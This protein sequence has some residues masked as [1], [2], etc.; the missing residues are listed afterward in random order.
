MDLKPF[1][2]DIDE[3]IGE[4]AEGGSTSLAEMKSVWLSKKFTYIFEASPSTNQACFMQSLFAYCIGYVVSTRSLSHRLGGLYCLYCLFE[5]QPFRPPFKIYLSLGELKKL[6]TLVADAKAKSI[7]VVCALVKSM[8]DR[9]MFLIGVVDINECSATERINEVTEIQNARIRTAYEKL[10]AN[11]KIE[12]FTRLDMGLELDLDSIKQ[13]STQY[14]MAKKRAIEGAS[15]TVDVENIKHIAERT[16]S[17]G[18]ALEQSAAD[19]N[20]QKEAFYQQTGYRHQPT[21]ETPPHQEEQ[22]QAYNK[23]VEEEDELQEDNDADFTKELEDA[24]FSEQ[25][26]IED[27]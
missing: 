23:D 7:E 1:K 4:F 8:L 15:K 17:V 27:E 3:L 16:R 13:R 2:L 9:N 12:L 11:T 26:M 5:T 6:R 18:D 19:W 21:S 14:A 20:V 10:F 25:L 22:I 24:L